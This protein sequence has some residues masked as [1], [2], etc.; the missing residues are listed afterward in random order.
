MFLQGEQNF[1]NYEPIE[2]PATNQPLNNTVIDRP[3]VRFADNIVIPPKK[4]EFPIEPE[5]IIFPNENPKPPEPYQEPTD[6]LK[7]FRFPANFFE[8]QRM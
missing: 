7:K 1:P 4:R 2:N 8:S 6:F 3:R 5:M